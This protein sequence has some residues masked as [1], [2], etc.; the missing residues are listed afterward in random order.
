MRIQRYRL[1]DIAPGVEITGYPG[2]QEGP[3]KAKPGIWPRFHLATDFITKGIVK[4]PIKADKSAW[5]TRDDQGNSVFRMWTKTEEWRAYHFRAVEIDRKTFALV[6][7]GK[8]I[9]KDSPIAI[10]GN[11]GVVNG[12][13]SDR[14]VHA[15]Q[16]IKPG[17]YDDELTERFEDLWKTNDIEDEKKQYGK[18]YEDQIKKHKIIRV[19]P[20]L[21]ERFDPFWQCVVYALNIAKVFA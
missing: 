9:E 7:D 3:K 18:P 2:W 21:I 8:A 14:C 12:E 16:V 13:G 11:V 6:N 15:L 4:T 1:E 17:V 20:I 10:P 19:N 5:I